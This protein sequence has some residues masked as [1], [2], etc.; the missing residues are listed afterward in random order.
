[1]M[2]DSITVC[3][4]MFT[5]QGPL[6]PSALRQVARSSFQSGV[7]VIHRTVEIA[8]LGRARLAQHLKDSAVSV[9]AE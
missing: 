3:L 2:P 6:Y 4:T 9:T 8:F 1:M 5:L 7:D